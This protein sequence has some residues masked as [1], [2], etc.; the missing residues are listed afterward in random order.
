[1][2]SNLIGQRDDRLTQ[3]T[4][5]KN[6]PKHG[7][8]RVQSLPFGICSCV[9][10]QGR[11]NDQLSFEPTRI[12]MLFVVLGSTLIGL[13]SRTFADGLP[14]AELARKNDVDF[15]KEVLPILRK[16]CLACHNETEA[17][18]DLILESVATILKGGSSGPAVVKKN[19]A[20]SYLFTLASHADEPIMPPED[21]EVGA[22]NLSPQ[23]LA[24]LKI[25]IEQ[26]APAGSKGSSSEAIVSSNHSP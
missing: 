23:E 10:K 26:G 22:S 9:Q 5:T 4:S 11:G 1:M 14:V 6:T 21:N 25:W 13:T 18:G 7:L 3:Q 17:E 15:A 24:I 20:E 19:V 2:R 12:A 8:G 16:N